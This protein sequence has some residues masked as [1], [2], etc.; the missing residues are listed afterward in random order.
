MTIG[1]AEIGSG[2]IGDGVI[3]IG[4]LDGVTSTAFAP[5]DIANLVFWADASDATS[6]TE[7][8][9]A[10][11]QWNDKSGKDFHVTQG[12]G[13]LQPI[14]DSVTINSLNAIDFDG[15]DDLLVNAAMQDFTT[16]TI[17]VVATYSD[18]A[19]DITQTL[20]DL[21]PG[22]GSNQGISLRA[23]F[24]ALQSTAS[25]TSGGTTAIP[26]SVILDQALLHR[27]IVDG[28]NHSYHINRDQ[29][30]DSILGGTLQNTISCLDVGHQ[31]GSSGFFLDG[32]MGEIAIFD[33]GLS[34]AN[35]ILMEDYLSD[36]WGITLT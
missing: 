29:L 27:T 34:A 10:V 33:V 17:F 12:T 1:S 19:S 8:A 4:R 22:S 2:S 32:P 24:G 7:S 13:S 21:S 35:I 14:T 18:D 15:V 3:G 28:T 16:V 30:T 9:G 25:K 26:G 11:S 36:K 20:L 31:F 23:N 6:I 5:T